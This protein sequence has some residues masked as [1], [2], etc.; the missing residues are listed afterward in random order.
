METVIINNTKVKYEDGEVYSFIKKGN[1]KNYKWFLL[2]G[3]INK[4]TGYRIIQINKKPYLYHRVIYKLFNKNWDITDTSKTNQIDHIDRNKLNNNIENLRVVTNQENS[5]NINCKG[6]S[7]HIRKN[8]WQ[9]GIKLNGELK[10]GGLFI[11]EEDAKNKYLEMKKEY[12]V[13]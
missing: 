4:E 12:H 5:F 3:T 13:I 2:K 10:Y 9:V 8:K 1:C 7:W 11:H 6:Y